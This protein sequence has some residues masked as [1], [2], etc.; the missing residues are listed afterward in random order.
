MTM[1]RFTFAGLMSAASGALMLMTAPGAHAQ[2]A[3]QDS[4]LLDPFEP[5]PEIQFRHFGGY[6]CWDN[7]GRCNDGCRSRCY[8]GCGRTRCWRDGCGR[9]HCTRGCRNTTA[10][11]R[12]ARFDR[13]AARAERD[14]YRYR[15]DE[16]RFHHDAHEY[17]RDDRDWHARYGF[18]R[19]DHDGRDDG[20]WDHHGDWE[21]DSNW[22]GDG[23]PGAAIRHEEHA[24][25]WRDGHDAEKEIQRVIDQDDDDWS[26]D[27]D[28]DGGT[29]AP[30]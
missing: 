25:D 10:Y 6:D 18:D 14:H 1:K 28:Y 9:L 30:R 22:D 2:V 7:C 15:E 13:D 24:R 12:G 27:E 16:R 29:P 19:H 21:H 8:R 5:V 4:A 11:D 3:A 26:D 17:E 23:R 20:H